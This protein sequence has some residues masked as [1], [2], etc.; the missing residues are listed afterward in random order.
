MSDKKLEEQARKYHLQN[1]LE[2]SLLSRG[3]GD[4]DFIINRKHVIEQLSQRDNKNIA[5]WSAVIAVFG[6][7]ISLL[8]NFS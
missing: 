6:A 2:Q 4:T 3:D 1:F 8:A 7:I 5:L